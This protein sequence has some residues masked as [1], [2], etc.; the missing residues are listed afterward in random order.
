LQ[1][2]DT[3]TDPWA[4]QADGEPEFTSLDDDT[5]IRVFSEIGPW[6][7]TPVWILDPDL[8]LPGVPDPDALK[9]G[10][11][12]PLSGAELR[13]YIALRSYADKAGHSAPFVRTIADRANVQRT[14]AERAIA[15]FRRLGW[16]R[17]KRRYRNDGSI[18]RCDYYLVDVCPQ[19][20]GATSPRDDGEEVP[21]KR[22]VPHP[23]NAGKGTREATG[24]KNTPPEH[25]TRTDQ[26]KERSGT[27]SSRF[28]PSGAGSQDQRSTTQRLHEEREADRALFLGFVAE[29]MKSTGQQFTPGIFT[30]DSVYIGLLKYRV[31]NRAIKFPGKLLESIYDVGGETGVTTYLARL[32]LEDA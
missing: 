6:A 26:G 22:R 8:Y 1:D 31:D 15:K 30:A 21:V 23:R 18:H 20:E 12:R 19:S 13:V 9:E 32:G 27:A 10:D 2:S 17:T 11:D 5:P 4:Q 14:T 3:W 29:K 24:A 25:T 16:L 28:A 7:M